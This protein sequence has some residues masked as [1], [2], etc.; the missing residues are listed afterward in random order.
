VDELRIGR[1]NLKKDL[2]ERT[3]ELRSLVGSLA[4]PSSRTMQATESIADALPWRAAH[5][6]RACRR[7]C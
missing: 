1:L 3:S 4:A 6:M 5:C 2:S 7:R